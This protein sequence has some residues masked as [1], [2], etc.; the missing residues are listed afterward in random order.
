MKYPDEDIQ[1]W[2]AIEAENKP[3]R[4]Q[5]PDEIETGY[6][7][8]HR[9]HV[10]S[11]MK[12][13][14]AFYDVDKMIFKTEWGQLVGFGIQEHK[15]CG[16][17]LTVGQQRTFSFLDDLFRYA[18]PEVYKGFYLIYSNDSDFERSDWLQVNGQE[19][20]I[21]QL[22]DLYHLRNLD[23]FGR[24]TFDPVLKNMIHFGTPN[25]PK[26]QGEIVQIEK[27]DFDQLTQELTTL[28]NYCTRLQNKLQELEDSI[29]SKQSLLDVG[30]WDNP[31]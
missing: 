13:G 28:K 11:W 25:T 7:R 23:Q 12:S 9:R 29:V 24:F 19:V 3:W 27:K 21:Y 16:G 5:N 15:C 6:S 10:K 20:T 14:M 17:R 26:I 31:K 18:L 30:F 2:N 4:G 22:E 8:F 1:K